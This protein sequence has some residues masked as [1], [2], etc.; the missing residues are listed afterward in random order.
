MSRCLPGN[1]RKKSLLSYPQIC[2]PYLPHSLVSG[3]VGGFADFSWAGYALCVH[4]H[5]FIYVHTYMCVY[6]LQLNLLLKK[7]KKKAWICET[8]SFGLC[9]SS[10][11]RASQHQL[12]CVRLSH[13]FWKNQLCVYLMDTGG[14]SLTQAKKKFNSK[15]RKRSCCL[16]NTYSTLHSPFVT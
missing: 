3:S 8:P 2:M 12:Q 9:T 13:Y 15:F 6:L 16:I 11:P 5:S 7:K 4:I 1:W 14:I 10:L